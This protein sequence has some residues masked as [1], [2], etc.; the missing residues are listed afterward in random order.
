MLSLADIERYH[1][2]GY[3]F[4]EGVVPDEQV[5]ALREVADDWVE[6]AHDVAANG[7]LFDLEPGHTRAHPQVRRVKNPTAVNQVYES[8]MRRRVRP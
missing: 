5:A 8:V 7:D 2:D 4:V 6:A 3:L 1:R